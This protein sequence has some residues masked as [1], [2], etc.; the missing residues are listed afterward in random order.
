MADVASCGSVRGCH[1]SPPLQSRTNPQ[2]KSLCC[3]PGAVLF[4]FR[5]YLSPGLSLSCSHSLHPSLLALAAL[6]GA[7]ALAA[8][9]DGCQPA[10]NNRERGDGESNL[11]S[12]D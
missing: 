11:Y 2:I 1:I 4:Y 6:F 12:C 8:V 7:L 10:V 9:L 5:L 3:S